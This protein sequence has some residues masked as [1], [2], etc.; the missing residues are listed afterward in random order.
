MSF[1][2]KERAVRS[3]LI[4]LFKEDPYRCRVELMDEFNT[5]YG[6]IAA[7][8]VERLVMEGKVSTKGLCAEGHTLYFWNA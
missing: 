5:P 8:E 6:Y 1:D 2:K 7:A 4:D 3:I